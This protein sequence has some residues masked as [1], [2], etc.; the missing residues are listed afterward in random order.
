[1]LRR[2]I[3]VAA[4]LVVAGCAGTTAGMSVTTT[5][6]GVT[7][8]IPVTLS[9]PEGPGPFPA[10]VVM[11]DCSGVGPASSGGPGRWAKELV[12][13]GYVVVIP[14]S[15]TP[16]GH[17]GGVCTVP[18]SQRRSDS[19]HPIRYVAARINPNAPG[20]RGATT[21]G[22]ASAWTDS[23]RQVLAFFDQHLKR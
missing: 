21:G 3:A 2:R 8:Q 9:K 1:M 10:V 20:G 7:E 19:P 16:R 13:R 23:I 6:S 11:H 17:P 5:A 15:F 14:D 22:D 18:I 4:C 12:A